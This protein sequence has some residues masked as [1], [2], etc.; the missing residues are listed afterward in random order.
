MP[1]RK[2]AIKSTTILLIL[3][4]FNVVFCENAADTAQEEQEYKRDF[5]RVEDMRAFLRQNSTR[6]LNAY[7]KFADSIDQKWRGRNKEYY[8]R[9]MSDVCAPLGF[10]NFNDYRQY[11]LARKYALSALEEPDSIPIELEL[12]LMGSVGTCII[13]P[14]AQSG[15]VYAERRTKDTEVRLHAWKRFL[16]AFD[17]NWDPKEVI[18]G[19]NVPPP[20]A[21]GFSPGVDPAAIQDSALRAEYEEAIRLNNEAIE[22]FEEQNLLHNKWSIMIPDLTERRIIQAYSHPPYATDELRKM[23]DEYLTDQEVK[24]RIIQT[25]EKN[26]RE[27]QE[28][29]R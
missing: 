3:F 13:G 5:N 27:A 6:D 21:T 4:G 10:G 28:G 14:C 12:T 2:L 1:I 8:A 25:V 24:T 18:W 19:G 11:E 17:P 23:L 20:V 26:I 9:L 16:E 15:Y 22:N 7:E 29:M